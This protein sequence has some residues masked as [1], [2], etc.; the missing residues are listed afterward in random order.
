M[1][2]KSQVPLLTCSRKACEGCELRGRLLCVAD[3]RDVLDFFLLFAVVFVPFMAGMIIGRFWLGI[4]AWFGL[5]AVFFGYVEALVL[6]RHCPHY[7]EK[8][9][10]LRC[11]ANWGLPKVPKFDPRPLTRAE[12]IVWLLYAGVLALWYVPFFVVSGQWLLLLIIS[13][14]LVAAVWTVWRTQCNRCYN[15]SCPMN[16]VPADVRDKFYENYPVFDRSR[17]R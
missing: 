8:G 13:V 1:T 12:Q 15:L 9:F 3:H 4:L 17:K 14:A 2:Q 16:R 7:G 5:A 10:L 6:C 11:H